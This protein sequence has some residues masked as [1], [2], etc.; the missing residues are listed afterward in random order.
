MNRTIGHKMI[1]VWIVLSACWVGFW[2]WY[3]HLPSCGSHPGEDATIG[4]HCDGPVAEGGSY[5]IVPLVVMV[6]VIIGV[7][8][9]VLLMGV[10]IRLL[11]FQDQYPNETKSLPGPASPEERVGLATPTPTPKKDRDEARPAR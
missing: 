8:I 5:E 11:A 6:A 1:K 2:S 10:A 7:P 9:A 3:Y 4:W